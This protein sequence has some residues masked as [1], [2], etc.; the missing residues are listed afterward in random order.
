MRKHNSSIL[1]K[2]GIFFTVLIFCLA[3]T[4]ISYSLWVDD[5]DINFSI[6]IGK[7]Q[8]DFETTWARMY[9][10]PDNFTY[11][12]P[13]NNWA[14]YIKHYPNETQETFYLYAAQNMYVGQL[15]IWRN[16][17]HLFIK[18]SL[19]EN[20]S[21]SESHIH[22]ETTLYNIPQANGNPIPGL[23]AYKKNHEPNVI[24]Y[25]YEINWNESWNQ[26]LL[27][28]AAHAVVWITN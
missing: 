1:P 22:V 20:Y 10:Q 3:V 8:E 11:E 13:G 14:T 19:D 4:S 23:F 18:Y 15:I 27:F 5:V 16:N 24:E 21:M 6:T 17:T 28:I 26:Q 9:N 25:T 12:F 7:K 2:I